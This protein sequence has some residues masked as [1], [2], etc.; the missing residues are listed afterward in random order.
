MFGRR[1]V[2][3]FGKMASV[4]H[5]DGENHPRVGYRRKQLGVLEC[6]YRPCTG[7]NIAFDGTNHPSDSVKAFV[8]P[9]E[10]LSDGFGSPSI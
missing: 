7:L 2:A 8:P 10:N 5:T 4:I 6:S 1:R 9:F 3:H